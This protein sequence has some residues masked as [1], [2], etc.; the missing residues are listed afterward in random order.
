MLLVQC[1]SNTNLGPS[2]RIKRQQTNTVLL[3]VLKVSYFIKS[4]VIYNN[5][6]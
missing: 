1:I 3:V 4:F 6:Q 2:K 5:M